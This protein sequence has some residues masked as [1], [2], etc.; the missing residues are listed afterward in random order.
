MS[1]GPQSL[2]R[3]N[4]DAEGLPIQVLAFTPQLQ[5]FTGSLIVRLRICYAQ[6]PMRVYLRRLLSSSPFDQKLP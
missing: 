4:E 5:L 6:M 3:R 2:R 1:R